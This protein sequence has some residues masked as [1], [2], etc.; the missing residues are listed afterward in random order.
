MD[1]VYFTKLSGSY[2]NWLGLRQATVSENVAN[3]DTPKY[4]ARVV[5]PFSAALDNVSVAMR[6]T[7]KAHIS[8]VTGNSVDRKQKPEES[9]E[10]HI[11]GNSV[12]LEQ[13]MLKNTQ[14]A[15]SHSLNVNLLKTMHRMMMMSLRTQG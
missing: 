10:T 2:S 6:A 8:D 1:P 7:H 11:S 13:E 5:E 4:N 15:Q 12:V 9:W 14:V 3:I